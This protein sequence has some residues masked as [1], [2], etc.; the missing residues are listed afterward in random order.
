MVVR[1][2][3]AC[4][5]FWGRDRLS[6]SVVRGASPF[7]KSS[8]VR[9]TN[10]HVRG[11]PA[12]LPLSLGVVG[13]SR[14]AAETPKCHWFSPFRRSWSLGKGP[15]SSSRRGMPDK[16]CKKVGS[17]RTREHLERH[18]YLSLLSRSSSSFEQSQP[19][20]VDRAHSCPFR[21]RFLRRA[22]AN[23]TT[24]RRRVV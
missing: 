23:S 13:R 17:R 6:T 10:R 18:L 2:L 7:W 24:R 22:P 19:L 12:N 9:A 1:D 16:S 14:R 8:F 4:S 5:R 3:V 15:L 20:L 11:N 21:C